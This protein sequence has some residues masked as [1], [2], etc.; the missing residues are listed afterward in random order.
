M[1]YIRTE[2]VYVHHTAVQER[3]NS[4]FMVFA[5]TKVPCV[6]ILNKQSHVTFLFPDRHELT[7]LPGSP[8]IEGVAITT[9]PNTAYEMMKQGGRVGVNTKWSTVLQGAPLFL[10]I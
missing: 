9:T 8:V 3:G 2:Y 1:S 4:D 7:L 6:M 10:K 5:V